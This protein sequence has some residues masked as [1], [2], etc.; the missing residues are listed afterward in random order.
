[1]MDVS[2]YDA[3][4]EVAG[5]WL[6][7]RPTD[8]DKARQIG[9]VVAAIKIAEGGLVYRNGRW[10]DGVFPDPAFR[11]QWAAAT[12][13]PRIAYH[14]FRA[15]RNAIAQAQDV[16]DIWTSVTRTGDDRLCLDF[17]TQDGGSGNACLLAAASWMY[18]IEKTTGQA[19]IL[20]TYPSFWLEIGGATATWAKKYPLWLAQ[21]PLDNWIINLK[22]PPWSFGGSQLT[23]L[24]AKIQDG[25]LVPLDGKP[26]NRMLT[27]WGGDIAIW[28]FTARAWTKDI[29]GHPAI[30]KIADLNIIYKLWWSAETT[31]P[32]VIEPRRCPTCGQAWPTGDNL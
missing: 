9:I 13:R 5:K 29:P 28:Q 10:V 12:G 31:T 7:D 1:M 20:Y 3:R 17:E 24:L 4:R 11:V 23:D 14:F 32:P 26:Y 6:Y 22:L 30:K 19:P 2:L 21:W 27:P 16:L 18:E 8:W 15:N 25:R